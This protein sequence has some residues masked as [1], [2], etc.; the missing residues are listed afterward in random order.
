MQA[1]YENT[2][3]R[4]KGNEPLTVALVQHQWETEDQRLRDKVRAADAYV[5]ILDTIASGHQTLYDRRNKLDSRE[6]RQMVASD[7]ATLA[8]LVSDLRKAF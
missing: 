6:I 3:E 1:Y 2:I 7:V 4:N 8:P 5:K